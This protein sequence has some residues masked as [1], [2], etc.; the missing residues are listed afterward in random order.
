MPRKI[1]TLLKISSSDLDKKGAFDGFIDIDSR[2]HVDPS[3]LTVCRIPEFQNTHK[4]FLEYFNKILA[5]VSNSKS[6]GDRLWN[7]AHKRLQFKEIGNTALGY[8]KSGTGGNA[9]GPKLAGNI[10]PDP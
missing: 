4:D 6:K 2:L 1:S 5:L 9:I 8:S 7:E 3:L 10:P